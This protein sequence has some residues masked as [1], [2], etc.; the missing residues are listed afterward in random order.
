M[1]VTSMTSSSLILTPITRKPSPGARFITYIDDQVVRERGKRDGVPPL[2]DTTI[3][4]EWGSCP[5][6]P[7]RRRAYSPSSRAQQTINEAEIK[8][9]GHRDL[10]SS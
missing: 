10:V 6:I 7:G 2:R 9:A 4:I 1:N 5:A 8:E 3:R